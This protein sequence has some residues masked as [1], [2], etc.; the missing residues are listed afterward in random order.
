MPTFRAFPIVV[1]VLVCAVAGAAN[2]AA[3]TLPEPAKAAP[4]GTAVAAMPD[5]EFYL[6]RG[7][8]DAC[9]HGCNEWIAAE[10][11]IDAGAAQRLRGL[12]TKLGRRRPPLYFHSPGGSMVGSIELGRFMREQKLVVSVAHTI[13]LGCDRDKQLEK[14]CEAQKRSGQAIEAE[15]DP[16]ISMC[17]SGCVWVIA[18]AAVRLVPPWVKLG[19]HDVGIDPAVKNPPTGAAAEESKRV[20]HARIQEY[21]RDMGIDRALYIATTGVPF[22]SKRFLDRDE[23]ARFGIDRREF[24]EDAWRFVDKPRPVM[25]KSFFV[26]TDDDQHRYVNGLVS[27]NCGAGSAI[28]LA[29]V[30]QHLASEPPG[31]WSSTVGI[32]VSGQRIDLTYLNPSPQFDTR[33]A[34]LSA[35]RLNAIGESAAI[36]VST[37]GLGRDGSAGSVTLSTDGFSAAYPKLRKGCDAAARGTIALAPSTL[38]AGTALA[39]S[40]M[41][42]GTRS[43]DPWVQGPLAD[44]TRG[45]SQKAPVAPPPPRTDPARP[46]ANVSTPAEPMKQSCTLQIADAPQHMTGRVT[47]FPSGEEVSAAT[48]AVE[49]QLGAKIN[50]AYLSLKRVTVEAYP[51]KGWSTMAAIPEHM[52]VKADDLVELNSRYRDPSLPCHFIPWTINRRVDPPQ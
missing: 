20:I 35:D 13:A 42:L 36:G 44:A 32:S 50:P 6:A 12:L 45:A 31:T 48:K 27:L 23:I 18:G 5:I 22:E 47:G 4:A 41:P 19:I 37:F 34:A 16:N 30:R 25:V 52:A 46:D 40:T 51:Q 29:L 24:G 38:P 9:G 2:V 26:R 43:L 17:N 8:A 11:R 3:Q 7:E 21:S 14:S 10:G 1:A 15:F 33:S 49:A 39:P 28:V